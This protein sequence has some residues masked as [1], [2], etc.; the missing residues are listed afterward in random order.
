[1]QINHAY[2]VK[3]YK[4]QVNVSCVTEECTPATRFAA[5]GC[6]VGSRKCL[7]LLAAVW[8]QLFEI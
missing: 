6:S 4:T 2:C 1:M 7:L 5:A 3:L 8:K